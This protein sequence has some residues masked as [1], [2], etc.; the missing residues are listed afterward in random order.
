MP[1]LFL[2]SKDVLK[3]IYEEE[4]AGDISSD[5]EDDQLEINLFREEEENELSFSDN[6]VTNLTKN[7]TNLELNQIKAS[8][9]TSETKMSIAS[10][11]KI[12]QTQISS[13]PNSESKMS[14]NT[15]TKIQTK[16]FLNSNNEIPTSKFFKSPPK[17]PEKNGFKIQ[18]RVGNF[19]RC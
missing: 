6:F 12:D 19:M 10:C 18:Q 11:L 15:D 7:E 3:E 4:E 5:E 17:V 14:F 2:T 9:P 8:I 16:T 1:K 13:I